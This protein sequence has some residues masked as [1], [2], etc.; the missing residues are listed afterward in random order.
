MEERLARIEDAIS[1]IVEAVQ[2]VCEKQA[3]L[4][5]EVDRL[6]K[7]KVYERLDGIE[8]EFGSM[9]G[10]LND[11]IDGRR[12]REYSDSFRSSHPEFSRYEDIGKRFGLDV[13]GLAADKTYEA[14]EEER[15]GMIGTMLEELKGKFDDLIAALESHNQHEM[16][17]TPAEEK[18]EH[19]GSPEVSVEIE[20]DDAD[21]VDPKIRDI[22]RMFRGRGVA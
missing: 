2:M 12:K 21:G 17:E 6:G 4:D 19:G 5:E 8:S 11:I 16:A 22:A 7:S 14:P 9:V 20:T 10:G 3:A 18:A 15:E 1:R 13:Y